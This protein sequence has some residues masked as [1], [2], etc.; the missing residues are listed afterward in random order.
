MGWN[1]NHKRPRGHVMSHDRACGDHGFSTY[2]DARKN[3]RVGSDRTT[4]FEHRSQRQL[5]WDPTSRPD[6]VRE[7]SVRADEHVVFYV[8]AVPEIDTTLDRYSVSDHDIILDKDMVADVAIFAYGSTGKNMRESP[9]ASIG[10]YGFGFDDSLRVD[11]PV[12]HGYPSQTAPI[13][14]SD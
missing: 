12:G 9:D 10:S 11:E 5:P 6:I 4:S 7:R 2:G 3:S 8:D 13:Q 1:T 14:S